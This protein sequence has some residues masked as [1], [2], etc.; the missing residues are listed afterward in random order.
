MLRIF[1]NLLHSQ[2]SMLTPVILVTRPDFQSLLTHFPPGQ[3][4]RRFAEDI[5]RCIF[6]N[7][8]IHILITISLKFVPKGPVDNNPA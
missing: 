2:L 6:F 3:N 1:L 7:E 4:S 5:F 8:N